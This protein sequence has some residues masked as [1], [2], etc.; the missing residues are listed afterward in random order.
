M[1]ER[2][3]GSG[4]TWENLGKCDVLEK[5]G[6]ERKNKTKKKK[7]GS[8]IS[9]NINNNN[10]SSSR[11]HFQFH[12]TKLRSR[13]CQGKAFVMSCHARKHNKYIDC[14]LYRLG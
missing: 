1:P 9:N 2:A 10:N 3:E 13:E 12:A 6:R 11:G 7:G 4:K 8:T 14:W 5:L